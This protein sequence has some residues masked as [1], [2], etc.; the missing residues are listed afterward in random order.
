MGVVF[1][2]DLTQIRSS[3]CQPKD[4]GRCKQVQGGGGQVV[5]VVGVFLPNNILRLYCYRGEW[6]RSATGG[7]GSEGDLW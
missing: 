2:G 4:I 7:F 3:A 6:L 1:E 5:Q